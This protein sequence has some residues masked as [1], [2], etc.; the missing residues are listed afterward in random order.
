MHLSPNYTEVKEI[1]V[2]SEWIDLKP[3][4][5]NLILR[6]AA[7]FADATGVPCDI[8]GADGRPVPGI[9][10]EAVGG[11]ECSSPGCLFCGMA[12]RLKLKKPSSC[13]SI[14]RYGTYQAERFGGR[15]IYFCPNNFAHWA[16]PLQLEGQ[17]IASFIGGP[18]LLIEPDEY[19]Q[20]E[21]MQ[22]RELPAADLRAL[23]DT[24][25]RI[26]FATPVRVRSLS[27][28]LYRTVAGLSSQLY[29]NQPDLS[30][31]TDQ[32]SRIAEYIHDLNKQSDN[33][34]D[35]PYPVEKENELMQL[36]TRGDKSNSQKV[37]NE[38]LGHIFFV[39]GNDVAKIRIRVQELVVLLSR[40]A[41]E[42]GASVEE[43][44][45]LNN[46]YL[47]QLQKIHDIDDIAA[48]LA[49]ILTRFSDCVFTLKSVKHADLIQK[50]IQY[51]NTNYNRK[52]SLQEVAEHVYM[53]PS[54]FSKVFKTEMKEGYVDFLNRIRV[55]KSKILLRERS[56]PLVD[57]SEMAGFDDQSYFSRVFKQYTGMSPGRF[58][59]A[60]GLKA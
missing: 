26:P 43:V 19:L 31:H 49:R 36:V 46:N 59:A 53:S 8:I 13:E 12:A 48:W 34:T 40:A 22:K 32:S 30:Q 55:D 57:I 56:I 41:V 60:R 9:S 38:I 42:G 50:A 35:I 15:Y 29:G 5:Q 39:A 2:Y 7:Q 25:S 4:T 17:T 28:T 27:E 16:V 1:K 44:F 51:M 33:S 47:L 3:E 58:R 20:D 10:A 18:V 45:G 14:H 54:H 52:I 21:I 37:L 6:T 24:L 23:R 11:S